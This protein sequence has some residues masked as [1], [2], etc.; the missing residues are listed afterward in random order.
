MELKSLE[1]RTSTVTSSLRASVISFRLFNLSYRKIHHGYH[2][3][4]K[5][6]L[7]ANSS[8]NLIFADSA[9]G[10]FKPDRGLIQR[11]IQDYSETDLKGGQYYLF[12]HDRRKL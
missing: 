5:G 8:N 11:H 2:C 7:H 10:H 1:A 12:D 6:V 4:P 9:W 3:C